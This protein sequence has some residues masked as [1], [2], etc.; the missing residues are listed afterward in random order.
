MDAT[1]QVLVSTGT[2]TTKSGY[3][4]SLIDRGHVQ[5]EGFG[6]GKAVST[7]VGVGAA[8]ACVYRH[9]V[10]L[11]FVCFHDVYFHGVCFH[12]VYFH[13]VCFHHV[14]MGLCCLGCRGLFTSPLIAG[15]VSLCICRQSMARL[16]P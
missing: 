4:V 14:Y 10:Y 6:V 9:F 15:F 8:R 2:P 16:R 13:S 7:T 12:D 3:R 1:E 11:H 5:L